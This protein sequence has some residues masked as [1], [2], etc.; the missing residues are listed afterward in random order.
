MSDDF[1]YQFS[2]KFG[3]N[4]Q[5]M[6]NVRAETAEEFKALLADVPVAELL[7]SGAVLLGGTYVKE[8]LGAT[9]V[10]TA[11]VPQVPQQ[12]APA[13]SGVGPACHHGTKVWREAPPGSGKTW[14]G[15]FCPSPKGTP[16]Q[17]KADFVN[18]R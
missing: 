12:S 3:P 9:A 11:A 1:K 13:Q 17:C 14:K 7:E 6:L 10:E 4:G 8:A 15:W 2:A 18:G 16:D 5:N